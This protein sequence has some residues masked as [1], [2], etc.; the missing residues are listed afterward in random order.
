MRDNIMISGIGGASLGTELA[1]AL[2][3]AGDYEI[4]GC[5]ISPSAYGLHDPNFADGALIRRDS[6]ISDVLDLCHR[7]GIA[8]VIP[9]GEEPLRLLDAARAS[10]ETEGLALAINASELIQTCQDKSNLFTTL[11]ALG[12]AVPWTRS[13]PS[14]DALEIR[15]IPGY[16]CILKPSTISGGSAYVFLVN[17]FNQL[18]LYS[19][20][21]HEARGPA[22]IQQYVPHDEGEFTVGVLSL[23]DGSVSGSIALR[24]AFDA[25]LSVSTSDGGRLISSGYSQGVIERTPEI[26]A[27]A[28]RIAVLL[29]STGPLNIQGRLQ[30]GAFL[31]F[32]INP[33]FSASTYLR[34]MAGFNE[35][36]IYLKYVLHGVHQ[37]PRSLR[38]GYYLRSLTERFVPMD[39]VHR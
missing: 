27:Q 13:I 16:P 1:K 34:T 3:A 35:V 18:K 17:D 33:R 11:E 19:R 39:R 20:L 10:F 24:R 36:D 7:W 26:C 8:C 15:D 14:P 2:A 5:D 29:G 9:G 6:Y 28:E 37:Q 38:A 23:P 32:E 4:Y 12:V 31:P 30:N 22:V 21:I 25:R